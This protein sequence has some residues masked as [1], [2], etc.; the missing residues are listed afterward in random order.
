MN[1]IL[2]SSV[3]TNLSFVTSIFDSICNESVSNAVT[4]KMEMLCLKW[5]SCKCSFHLY[6]MMI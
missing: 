1:R 2:P 3:L 6:S 5:S 4:L